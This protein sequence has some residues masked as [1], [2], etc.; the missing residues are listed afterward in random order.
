MKPKKNKPDSPPKAPPEQP[1]PS[2]QAVDVERE[3]S[4]RADNIEREDRNGPV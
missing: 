2:G 3:T 1:P 4:A